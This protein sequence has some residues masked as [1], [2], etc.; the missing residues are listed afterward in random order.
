MKFLILMVSI[1]FLMA[2]QTFAGEKMYNDQNIKFNVKKLRSYKVKPQ[3]AIHTA[4]VDFQIKKIQRSLAS[5][6]QID[7]EAAGREPSSNTVELPEDEKLQ[8]WDYEKESLE[9]D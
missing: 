2:G 6:E 8:M 7:E 1:L 3:P 5:T 4:R 9:E